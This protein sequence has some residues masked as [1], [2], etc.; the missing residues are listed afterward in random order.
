MTLFTF[1][2]YV[3]VDDSHNLDAS[4]SFVALSYFNIIRLA[5][6]IMPIMI[7]EGIKVSPAHVLSYFV[8]PCLVL[9]GLEFSCM[10]R[11][12]ELVMFCVALSAI[13]SFVLTNLF[14]NYLVPLTCNDWLHFVCPDL[15][16]LVSSCLALSGLISFV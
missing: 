6:N 8:L 2:T 3:Y 9:L 13:V 15:F 5:V 11:L 10:S 1:M 16:C 7:R 12:S 14:L 4:T